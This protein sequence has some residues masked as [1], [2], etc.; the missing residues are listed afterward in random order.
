MGL[1]V[2]TEVHSFSKRAALEVWA[3]RL[4]LIVNQRTETQFLSF[5]T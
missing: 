2:V 1:T 5:G 4:N 3:R